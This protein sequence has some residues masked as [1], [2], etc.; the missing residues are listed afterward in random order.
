M[1]QGT[2]PRLWRESLT[3]LSEAECRSPGRR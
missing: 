1:G 3:G 2:D